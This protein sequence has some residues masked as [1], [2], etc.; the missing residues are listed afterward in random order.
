MRTHFYRDSSTYDRFCDRRV[1]ENFAI[2]QTTR[3]ALRT[4]PPCLVTLFLQKQTHLCSTP[5]DSVGFHRDRADCKSLSFCQNLL[6]REILIFLYRGKFDTRKPQMTPNFL[7]FFAQGCSFHCCCPE[8]NLNDWYR[9]KSC[10]MRGDS[11]VCHPAPK[12]PKTFQTL[13][14]LGK[15]HTC[16]HLVRSGLK[17]FHY[18][19]T[20]GNSELMRAAHKS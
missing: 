7:E 3:L 10:K 20:P 4:E 8:L 6:V 18:F 1:G 16:F 15:Q 9:T 19:G 14:L 13:P 11:R 2:H 17:L 12:D 5:R